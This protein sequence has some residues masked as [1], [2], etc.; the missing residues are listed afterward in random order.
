MNSRYVLLEMLGQGGMGQVFLARDRLT[1]ELVAYKRLLPAYQESELGQPFRLALAREFEILASVRHPNIIAVR[2]YG[3]SGKT[4]FF[5]MDYLPGA[6]DVL[7]AGQALDLAGKAGLLLQAL[8]ALAYL[9]RRGV[10]HRDLKPENM[11]VGAASAA[12]LEAAPGGGQ[13]RLLDFGLAAWMEQAGGRVGTLA[14]IAP[15][16][17]EHGRASE[18]SDL[19]ALGVV[20][21]QLFSGRLPYPLDDPGGL[22]ARRPD[23]AAF[24]AHAGLAGV[25]AR[26]VAPRP[27]GRYP[28]A[29]EAARAL[30]AALDLPGVPESP[31]ERESYL[32]AARFTGRQ[33]ELAAL[34]SALA[35]GRQ[36]DG[37]AWLVGGERGAGK[38]R[39]LDELRIQAL[40]RGA[41]V[42]TARPAG[43]AGPAD[44][45]WSALL[46]PLALMADLD[47]RLAGVLLPL[48]D[49]LPELLGRPVTPAAALA[50]LDA[51]QR[52]AAAVVEAACGAARRCG[53]AEQ[54][55]GTV[56]LEPPSGELLEVVDDLMLAQTV[57]EAGAI[58]GQQAGSETQ[59][60]L[61][62]LLDDL[63]WTRDEWE[64][65]QLLATQAAGLP[66]VI[67]GAY[68]EDE[69][70]DLPQALPAFRRLSLQRLEAAEVADLCAAM[71]GAA[72]RR[73]A[74]LD[75]LE[76]ETAGN[77]FFLVETVRL[78]A[79]DA[80]G[81]ER[82]EQASLPAHLLPGSVAQ[83]LRLR[84][85]RLDP[86]DLPLLQLAAAGG[87]DLDLAVLGSL[88]AGGTVDLDGWLGRG[89]AFA[90]LEPAPAH[91]GAADGWRFTHERLRLAVLEDQ[92]PEALASLHRRLAL[93]I[94]QIYPAQPRQA[95][96][97]A[98]HWLAAGDTHRS[99]RWAWQ[100]AEYALGRM[101]YHQALDFY[102]RA[103]DLADPAD[104][105]QLF[106]LHLGRLR[107]VDP[108]GLPAGPELQQLAALAEQMDQPLARAEAA[109]QQ[110]AWELHA[111]RPEA[112]WQA[113]QHALQLAAPVSQAAPVDLAAPVEPA[114]GA[115]TDRAQAGA[116]A[117][118][119][120]AG[121]L[122]A[123]AQLICGQALARQGADGAWQQLEAA[124]ETAR[125]QADPG[126]QAAALA[127]MGELARQ[128]GETVRAQARLEQAQAL[129]QRTGSR[130]G[131]AEAA[132][133]LGGTYHDAG[134]YA[135][136]RGYYRQALDLCR[137][138][139]A[140]RLE[141]SVLTG[142]GR[143]EYTLHNLLA[144]RP[145]LE[146]ALA[147]ARQVGDR[148]LEAQALHAAGMLEI[149][150]GWPQGALPAL[151]QALALYRSLCEPAR[152]SR[153][154]LGRALAL[155]ELGQLGEAAAAGCQAL[156][157]AEAGLTQAQRPAALLAE[158]QALLARLALDGGDA[159]RAAQ[160]AGAVLAFLDA[161]GDFGA[162]EQ[163]LHP[164]VACILALQ[165]AGSQRA[166]ELIRAAYRL[167]QSR[168]AR[169]DE[170][171]R[172]SYL[173]EVPYHRQLIVLFRRE[174]SPPV[175]RPSG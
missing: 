49:D 123:R 65:L 140:L 168:A 170:A 135:A 101:A 87:R 54:S 130:Q 33:P 133:G 63:Q 32:Q 60:P 27:E 120:P 154:L 23:P 67:V 26:L 148:Q 61:L 56:E 58:A 166:G 137:L 151:E 152:Q 81:L 115:G 44:Q 18:A 66:L 116:A 62:L 52:L 57:V 82:L 43:P 106:D 147:L 136:A 119:A 53:P 167:L 110:A 109:L 84:L 40:V 107:L 77:A 97:L 85:E 76:R 14:Y 19:F 153:A 157:L 155:Y 12:A 149:A 122:A 99:G 127:A 134:L 7:A 10:L 8:Q 21:C 15:E 111:G 11:M 70:P 41:A 72:G 163:P 71:L 105:R 159:A 75:L 59:G 172:Y 143:T 117:W 94:E 55:G 83:V 169:L 79:S 90:V 25:L 98:E 39:L 131:L 145:A 173:G 47:D 96:A 6:V 80:G 46:R 142:L 1:G 150:T 35:A 89:A 104:L 88:A 29:V 78:L 45:L 20:A 144:A 13:L 51:R 174:Y 138:I 126:L 118:P 124:L 102:Q 28:S 9:H 161:G 91:S 93:A 158:I 103:I 5:T 17:L 146:R 95:A 36:G 156:A 112:A 24:P 50:P 86:A 121:S 69:S 141:S 92:A 64:S 160:H 37:S 125:Q 2:D 22:L 132:A 31:A 3:V 73:P 108:L 171:A 162:A 68:R 165:A 34:L 164:Y 16:T 4:P 38:T 114:A 100:A 113:A 139:G 129:Y 128:R 48:V 175:E 42:L 30:R 74:L